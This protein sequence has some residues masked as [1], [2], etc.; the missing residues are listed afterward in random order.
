MLNVILSIAGYF[1]GCINS[2][3]ILTRLIEKKDVRQFGSKNAG[4]TNTLRSFRM[5]TAILVFV[6]D[7]LKA[8]VALSLTLLFAPQALYFVAISVIIG[9]NFPIFYGFK[10]GKGVLVSIVSIL[11]CDWRVGLI[12]FA[13]S[14]AIMFI[15]GYV[16]LGSVIGAVLLPIMALIFRFGD[17]QFLLFSIVISALSIF[18]HRQNIHRLL[19]GTENRFGRRKSGG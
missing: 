14:V 6:G 13:V 17:I 10:G 7:A 11:F 8:A 3:I 18:M 15:S 19:L 4:F 5:R 12:I 9:H 2:S 1:L 16:S